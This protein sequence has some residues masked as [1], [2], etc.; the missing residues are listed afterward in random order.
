MPAVL[1][2]ANEEAVGLFMEEKIRFLDIPRI[3]ENVMGRHS[4]KS[5]PGID[6][7]I[8]VDL[9]AR[10]IVREVVN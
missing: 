3:I 10:K 8:D 5:D 1:N 9:W 2:A 7:I 4:I 6:D